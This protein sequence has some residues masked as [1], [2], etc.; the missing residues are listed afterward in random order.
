MSSARPALRPL[1][2]SRPTSLQVRWKSS[3]RS[4]WASNPLI[5]YHELKPITE[6]PNDDVL[7]IDVREPDEVALGMIPSAVNLPLSTLKEALD[8]HFNPGQ[9]QKAYAFNKP[10]PTQNIVFYCRSGKRSATASELASERG[11]KN[12]RNYQGSYLDWEAREKQGQRSRFD[13]DD[14]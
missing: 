6:Q 8:P 4:A 13:D 7:L 12:I 10:L 2:L 5:D 9:F 1:A 14:D 11:Y 3:S